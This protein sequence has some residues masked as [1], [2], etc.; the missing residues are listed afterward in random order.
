[1]EMKMQSRADLGTDPLVLRQRLDGAVIATYILVMLVVPLRFLC[2]KVGKSGFWAD[3]WLAMASLVFANAIFYTVMIRGSAPVS[4]RK[5][6]SLLTFLYQ[7]SDRTWD[8][9]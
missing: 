6:T 1:M 5:G 4:S 2:R 9:T 3:D 7:P 8:S